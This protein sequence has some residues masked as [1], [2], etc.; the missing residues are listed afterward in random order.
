[1]HSMTAGNGIMNYGAGVVATRLNWNL[2]KRVDLGCHS[3][4]TV[5]ITADLLIRLTVDLCR[6]RN[7]STGTLRRRTTL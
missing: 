5:F 7:G 3:S 2:G 4:A 6:N 1:M